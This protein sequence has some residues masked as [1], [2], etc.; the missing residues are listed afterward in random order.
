MS[1]RYGDRVWPAQHTTPEADD[2]ARRFGVMRDLGATHAVME[3]SSHALALGRV[4]A[5][6]F[7]VAALTNI[8]Q[9]HLDFHG[10]FENYVEA[11]A[12]LFTRHGPGA[13]V[14]NVDD[15]SG[16][17]IASRVV[18]P[19]TYSA[20]GAAATLRVTQGGAHAE[21]VDAVVQT[22]DGEVILRSAL[23]GAHNVE[24][25]LAALGMLGALEVPYARAA[26][27]L[28]D[29]QGAPG[30]LERVTLP[31]AAPP[32]DVLVDYAHTDDALA[33]VLQ[34]LRGTT[35][36]R[37]LCVFGCGGDRDRAKR[38]RM[39]AAVA[40]G[41]HIAVLT[42]DNPR[43]ESPEAIAADVLPGLRG[44]MRE[45][46]SRPGE[47]EFAVILDRAEAIAAAVALARPG[48]VVL[49]A[50]KGHE[51]YQEVRGVRTPFDD[52]EVA[53]RALELRLASGPETGEG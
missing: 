19:I 8:T 40:Q 43:T 1:H 44:A 7:R 13:A 34:T 28:A 41:A 11:K 17:L 25:L 20:R 23:R 10:T 49:I 48:D 51:T 27:A 42:T 45:A 5:V 16:R 47:G 39:G 9:D 2:L 12:S 50:G 32:F 6:R 46:A 15:P 52:R 31:Q 3:V 38:P 29:A 14:L 30:R 53:A 33:R 21:G 36:G 26:A 37:V 4:A 22:P 24:N 35:R 18:A